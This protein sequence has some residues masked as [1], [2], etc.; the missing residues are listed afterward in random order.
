MNAH[1]PRPWRLGTNRRRALL[2]THIASAGG[3]KCRPPASD[4]APTNDLPNPYREGTDWGQ[5]PDGR[6]WGSS[7]SITT[8]CTV[9]TM[10]RL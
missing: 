6:K 9:A 10:K 4:T 3:R 7:A 5:L 1:A 8:A 2:I